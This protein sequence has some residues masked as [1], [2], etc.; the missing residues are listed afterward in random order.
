MKFNFF[1]RMEEANDHGGG[2]GGADILGGNTDPDTPPSD[3]DTSG[4]GEPPKVPEWLTGVDAEY[5]SDSSLS[6]IQDLNSLVKSYVHAQKMVGKDKIV[7]PDKYAT[8]EDWRHTLTKL[9]LPETEEN[10]EI[11]LGEESYVNDDFIGNFKKKAFEV[12]IMPKQAQQ[13]LEWYDSSLRELEIE[14]TQ[15]MQRAVEDTAAELQQEYGQ[16]FETKINMANKVLAEVA[17]D[18][19]MEH[20]RETGLVN[21]KNFV[22]MMVKMADMF[23]SEDSFEVAPHSEAALTPEEAK[24][25]I[26]DINGNPE[27]PYWNDSH[28]AHQTAVKDM[29]KLFAYL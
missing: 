10:Y 7:I 9:G 20:F 27:H 19:M 24:R 22:K 13:M 11:K 23:N 5:A 18:N 12:G 14:D 8:D 6:T 17:D 1:R 25:Q 26:A 15:N 16:A 4:G 21:D 29:N 2:E 3:P 28:P